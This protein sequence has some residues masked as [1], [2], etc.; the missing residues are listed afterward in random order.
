MFKE[1]PKIK[2]N[3]RKEKLEKLNISEQEKEILKK[4]KQKIL[5][6]TLLVLEQENISDL[7][8]GDAIKKLYYKYSSLFK[9]EPDTEDIK[10]VFEDKRQIASNALLTSYNEVTGND[11]KDRINEMIAYETP[12]Y[13]KIK[14]KLIELTRDYHNRLRNLL[15]KSLERTEK[16]KEQ[17]LK[18]LELEKLINQLEE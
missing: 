11:P 2:L 13:K 10:R 12:E 1:F 9:L 16:D 5:L 7:K 18:D 17:T 4:A 3:I 14:N 6:N 15:I 8:K